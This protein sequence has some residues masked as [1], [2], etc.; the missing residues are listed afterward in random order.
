MSSDR[1][2]SRKGVFRR[3]AFIR[4]MLLHPATEGHRS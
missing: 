4:V 1:I 3:V 2:A